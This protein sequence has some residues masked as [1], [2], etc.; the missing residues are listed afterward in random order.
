M[1]KTKTPKTLIKMVR[2][3]EKRAKTEAMKY[4]IPMEIQNALEVAAK[5]SEYS[6]NLLF[7]R[8]KGITKND[9]KLI[10][11]KFTAMGFRVIVLPDSIEVSWSK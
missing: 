7:G 8:F 1:A 6:I 3:A 5:N 9:W 11:N 10:A 4:D 2:E